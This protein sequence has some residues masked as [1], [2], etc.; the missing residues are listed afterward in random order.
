[1]ETRD[2]RREKSGD[3]RRQDVR[4]ETIRRLDSKKIFAK[5]KKINDSGTK[6]FDLGHHRR[7]GAAF[8]RNQSDQYGLFV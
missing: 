4:R 7:L 3:D 5:N 6:I 1:R 2:V 8:G